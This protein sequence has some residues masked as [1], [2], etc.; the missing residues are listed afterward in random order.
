MIIGMENAVKGTIAFVDNSL[1]VLEILGEQ[2]GSLLKIVLAYKAAAIGATAGAAAGPVG[3]VVGAGIGAAAGAGAGALAESQIRDSFARSRERFEGFTPTESPS[4][5]SPADAIRAAGYD[6]SGPQ[7][8]QE[9]VQATDEHTEAIVKNTEAEMKRKELAE[10][11]QERYKEIAEERRA[12]QE[13]QQ[14]NMDA[15]LE[16]LM[17]EI[18]NLEELEAAYMEG[19]A[20][21]KEL[22]LE[23]QAENMLTEKGIELTDKNIDKIKELIAARHELE[24]NINRIKSSLEIAEEAS[25]AVSRS[26]G[27]AFNS[28][29]LGT[30]SV[31]DAFKTM[32]RNVI[33]QLLEIIVTQQ[34]VA[35]L[36]NAIFPS[37]SSLLG[38][39]G[40]AGANPVPTPLPGAAT[41]GT[42]GSGD[43]AIVG[44]QGPELVRFGGPAQVYPHNKSMDMMGGGATIIQNFSINVQDNERLR[45]EMQQVSAS[46]ATQASQA[47]L[48][49]TRKDGNVR[50]TFRGG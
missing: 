25:N 41:G 47:L 45:D 32:A 3:A 20:A 8:I 43:F 10:A 18:N 14:V 21:V 31:S 22:N 17:S 26:F 40:G 34:L 35:A 50:R 11:I 49:Q 13:K 23:R 29:V 19:T 28:I 37:F 15:L 4:T 36:G 1:R 42:F 44:E 12:D 39:A 24:G 48:A 38:G 30:Q 5:T 6:L 7:K 9:I 27:D 2:W 33:A 46:A 16:S